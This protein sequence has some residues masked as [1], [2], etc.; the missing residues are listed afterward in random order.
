MLEYHVELYGAAEAVGAFSSTWSLHAPAEIIT[1]P[2]KTVWRREN[3]GSLSRLWNLMEKPPKSTCH[4]LPLSSV[5]GSHLQQTQVMTRKSI[6]GDLSHRRTVNRKCSSGEKMWNMACIFKWEG[7]QSSQH[8][9]CLCCL[10]CRLVGLSVHLRGYLQQLCQY[11][12][13]QNTSS[14]SSFEI[15]LQAWRKCRNWFTSGKTPEPKRHSLDCDMN[16]K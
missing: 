9:S 11:C 16:F 2:S 7:S 1:P 15:W 14:A 10:L 12:E 13:M 3:C 8:F 4:I 6:Q 5:S